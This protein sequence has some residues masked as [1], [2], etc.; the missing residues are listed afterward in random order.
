MHDIVRNER[1][2]ENGDFN[3]ENSSNEDDE[4]E[5][6]DGVTMEPTAPAVTPTNTTWSERR[7][8]VE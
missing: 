3:F 2:T 7:D 8:D 1:G 5:T 6:E 4:Q